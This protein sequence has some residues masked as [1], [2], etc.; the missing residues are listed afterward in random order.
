MLP[1]IRISISVLTLL[2]G[3]LLV[4][5]GPMSSD[6]VQWLFEDSFN[7]DFTTMDTASVCTARDLNGALVFYNQGLYSKALPI[8]EKFIELNLPDGR[9]IFLSFVAAECYRQ[10]ALH[11]RAARLYSNL[12]RNRDATDLTAAS[13]LRLAQYAAQRHDCTAA[14]TLL[15]LFEK[16]YKAHP[17]YGQ[18]LYTV[19]KLYAKEERPALAIAV[20]QKIDPHS[21]RFLPSQYLIACAWVMLHNYDK[22]LAILGNPGFS[23]GQRRLQAIDEV[24]QGDICFYLRHYRAAIVHYSRVDAE[25][26]IYEYSR[27]KLARTLQL[28]N[29]PTK[30]HSVAA[31]VL[32]HNA[33]TDFFFEAASILENTATVLKDNNYSNKINKVVNDQ[34]RV[35]ALSFEIND[36]LLQVYEAIHGWNSYA[37]DATMRNDAASAQ[38]GYAAATKLEKIKTNL[39]DMLL[40]IGAI[41]SQEHRAGM[42]SI[43]STRYMIMVKAAC[44]ALDRT[45]QTQNCDTSAAA[46]SNDSLSVSQDSLSCHNRICDSLRAQRLFLASRKEEIRLMAQKSTVQSDHYGRQ[47]QIKYIDWAFMRYQKLKSIHDSQAVGRAANREDASPEKD[48][49]ISN[50]PRHSLTSEAFARKPRASA[51]SSGVALPMLDQDRKRLISYIELYMD[52]PASPRFAP[53]ILMRLAELYYDEEIELFNQN[54]DAYERIAAAASRDGKKLAGVEFPECNLDKSIAAYDRIISG[55][56]Q[57]S[58]TDD[59]HFFKALALKKT[60]KE[61][62]ASVALQKMVNQFPHS[63]YFV[64]ANIAIGRYFFEHPSIQG[65][66]GYSR[67]QEAYRRVLAYPEHPQYITAIYQ[68]GWCYFMQDRYDDALTI[69]QF[70]ISEGHLNFNLSARDE[71]QVTNPLLREEAIDCLA[72]SFNESGSMENAIEFLKK[73]GSEDY[74]AIVFER[75]GQLREED[76]DYATALRIYRKLTKEYYR[77]ARSPY[78][79]Q[80]MVRILEAQ[81]NED[82]ALAG[83]QEFIKNYSPSSD[84]MR[85]HDST[86]TAA[87]DSMAVSAALFVADAYYRKAHARNDPELYRKSLSLYDQVAQ[88]YP[89]HK[90]AS[91]AIWNCGVIFETALS[92]RNRASAAYIRYSRWLSADSSRREQAALNAVALSQANPGSDSLG[93]DIHQAAANYCQ[94]FPNGRS[95]DDV[96]LLEGA[97]YFNRGSYDK[98]I[99][100]YKRIAQKLPPNAKN[101]EAQFMI[102][103]CFFGLEQWQKASEQFATVGQ[104][105]SC[106]TLRRSEALR[107]LMQ[108]LFLHGKQLFD[109]KQYEESAAQYANLQRRFP[110]SEVADK[111]LFNAAEAYE[112]QQK[113]L[114]A[115]DL[116][117][118][119]DQSYPNS[120]IAPDALF[121]AA[122]DYE[123]A[124]Q[125]PLVA[126]MYE[127]LIQRYPTSIKAKDG[128]FNLGFVYEKM[129]DY[130]KMAEAQHRY[131]TIYPNEKEVEAMTLRSGEYFY[132]GGL[133]EK[134]TKIYENYVKL[135]A[136]RSGSVEAWYM[137]GNCYRN[138]ADTA[139]AASAFE[140]AASQNE[141]LKQSTG[142]NND[143]F[144][145]EAVYA[146]GL[147]AK[148]SFLRSDLSGA[149][150]AQIKRK[151]ELK[152]ELLAKAIK[153]FQ[154][155]ISYRSE[156]T[157]DA[158]MQIGLLYE[159]F[160]LHWSN[161]PVTAA[162]KL[163]AA[164]LKKELFTTSWQLM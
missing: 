4:L 86:A 20:L 62:D 3:P 2:A 19:G 24:L 126:Q 122:S 161:Q 25:A 148:V 124:E 164:V 128:L 61:H 78:G 137:M 146:L 111:A 102:A 57:D 114:D 49:V 101:V 70:L 37:N 95:I 45:I 80:A 54:L 108:S 112:Q 120:S 52:L 163:Q 82:E 47:M 42:P 160:A 106:D 48:R 91:E 154:K 65:N 162:D 99:E 60:G 149:T 100:S 132:K 105:P 39:Q 9:N 26:P 93:L 32:S 125:L 51:D 74:A 68:L 141:K 58:L 33:S 38:V 153:A 117:R 5:A 21:E 31:Q 92:D 11:E 142:Q 17:M 30:S 130:E 97:A 66:T 72:M 152:T 6:S 103:K 34:N 46:E 139:R 144:A 143:Y 131:S 123:R 98:A 71:E 140:S 22:A 77:A 50:N 119:I 44:A 69:F 87:V 96:V 90:K 16:T 118:R 15:S 121:N 145:A 41:S 59:A 89:N 138:M 83:R 113:W 115:A 156:R 75:I 14:D 12:I 73:I 84:W 110:E 23:S 151:Q 133:Y 94:L 53:A 79:L 1:M 13:F 63:D 150:A 116:Y 35:V 64:D 36:E 159:Q 104:N 134:A 56:P 158:T 7:E 136:N 67:A 157:M 88:T 76:L 127:R 107:Y 129:K 81:G 85:Q 147:I 8:I 29:E 55:Y 40:N 43:T 28:L 155:V 135:Y 18:L 27:V 10:C 109:D